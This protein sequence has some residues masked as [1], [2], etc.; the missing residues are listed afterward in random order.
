MSV[1]E[2]TSKPESLIWKKNHSVCCHTVHES[3]AMEESLT[4]HIDGNEN[5]TNLLTKV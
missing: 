3:V 2:N 5:P 4:A 1:I